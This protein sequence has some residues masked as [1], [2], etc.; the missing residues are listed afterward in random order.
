M[1]CIVSNVLG[2]T[3]YLAWQNPVWDDDGYFW[4]SKDIM[5]KILC[6]NTKE[7]PFLFHN[8]RE[9]VK[10]LKSINIPYKCSIVRWIA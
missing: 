7:H 4:T 6:N 1:Y 8:K 3:M 2:G 5:T 10:H 9:A